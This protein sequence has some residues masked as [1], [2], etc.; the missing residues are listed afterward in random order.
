ME[1]AGIDAFREWNRERRENLSDWQIYVT[2]LTYL[3]VFAGIDVAKMLNEFETGSES[4]EESLDPEGLYEED[5]TVNEYGVQW[6]AEPYIFTLQHI[7]NNQ[8]KDFLEYAGEEVLKNIQWDQLTDPVRERMRNASIGDYCKSVQWS[9]IADAVTIQT[10]EYIRAFCSRDKFNLRWE[11][12][13]WSDWK[14]NGCRGLNPEEY[15]EYM[16]EK[17]RIMV[18]DFGGY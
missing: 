16:Y 14:E 5:W 9:V 15:D 12:K 8:N 18:R 13:L 7:S 4:E 10:Q 17:E 1:I 11:E 3:T 6:F 2:E